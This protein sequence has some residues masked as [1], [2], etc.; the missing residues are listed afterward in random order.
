MFGGDERDAQV[1]RQRYRACCPVF[2]EECASWPDRPLS[3][4][5]VRNWV[6]RYPE[7]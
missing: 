2:S 7:A 4:I 6:I 5:R 1:D 3:G